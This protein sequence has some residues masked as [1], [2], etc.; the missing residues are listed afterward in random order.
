MAE[1]HPPNQNS[2]EPRKPG[3]SSGG[4]NWRVL[5]LFA[6]ALGLLAIATTQVGKGAGKL[7][8]FAQF[9]TLLEE[10]KIIRNETLPNHRLEVVT[11][12]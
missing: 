11:R 7:I 10:G 2:N 5:I 6:I 12:E 9:K 8:S 1:E 3:E 4:F